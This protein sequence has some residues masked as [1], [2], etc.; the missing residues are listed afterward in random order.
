MTMGLFD[1]LFK[2]NE[3][4]F[5]S[6]ET[7]AGALYAPIV[8]N[9]IPLDQIPDEVFSQG[10]LGQGCGIEPEEGMVYAPLDGEITQIADT[11]HAVG[12]TSAEGAEILIHVGMDTVEMNGVGFTPKVKVGDKVRCGQPLLAFDMD[13]I[14]SA[15]HPTATAFVVTNSDDFAEIAVN[16]GKRYDKSG[17]IGTIR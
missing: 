7:E 3:P 9:Y 16:A 14:K 13:K 17:K 15:G 8:G 2:G 4:A 1:K 12:I 10:I 5:T 6:V 11:T